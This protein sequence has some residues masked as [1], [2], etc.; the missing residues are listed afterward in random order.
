M[1]GIEHAL[2][3]PEEQLTT[4]LLHKYNYLPPLQQLQRR[5]RPTQL[6]V[7]SGVGPEILITTYVTGHDEHCQRGNGV[8]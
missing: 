1:S 7:A 3:S 8:G 2:K 6:G 4:E 5:P